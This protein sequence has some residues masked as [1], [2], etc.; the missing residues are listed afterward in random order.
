ME[1]SRI[2]SKATGWLK[3]LCLRFLGQRVEASSPG[4]LLSSFDADE[5]KLLVRA[6]VSGL[7]G[8][9]NAV[10]RQLADSERARKRRSCKLGI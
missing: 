9:S 3:G 8:G 2:G 6:E 4:T 7:K 1:I 10:E 5:R